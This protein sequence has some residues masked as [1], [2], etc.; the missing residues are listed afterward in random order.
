MKD[1]EIGKK[2]LLNQADD[3]S[4]YSEVH[5]KYHLALNEIIKNQGFSDLFLIDAKNENIIYSVNK[6]SDFG[7]DLQNGPYNQSSLA[8]VV[9]KVIVNI[10]D[11]KYYKR[12]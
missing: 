1:A 11:L 5:N 9:R 10:S 2:N 8:K 4:Y 6:K 7:T 12:F 3:K